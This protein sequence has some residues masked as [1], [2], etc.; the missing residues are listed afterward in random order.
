M[1]FN[2]KGYTMK[3][4][5]RRVAIAKKVNGDM[6]RILRNREPPIPLNRKT[7][8][9]NDLADNNIRFRDM[10]LPKVSTEHDKHV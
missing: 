8:T 2:E 7:C 5:K 3:D 4:V 6:H 9:V 1:S 10:N